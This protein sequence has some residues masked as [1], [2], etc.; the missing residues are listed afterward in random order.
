MTNRVR[1]IL[2][3]PKLLFLTMGQRG[4]FNWMSDRLYLKI[5][6]KIKWEKACT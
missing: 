1:K 6:Y 5:A 3:N 4:F 2:R